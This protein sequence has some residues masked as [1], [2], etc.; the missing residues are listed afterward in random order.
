MLIS[1]VVSLVIIFI[2]DSLLNIHYFLITGR[3]WNYVN[4]I[5]LT[6]GKIEKAQIKLFIL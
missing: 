6:R 4:E 3:N 2:N 5:R 1:I